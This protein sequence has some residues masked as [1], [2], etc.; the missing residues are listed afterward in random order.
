MVR[1][2]ERTVAVWTRPLGPGR[3]DGYFRTLGS[4]SGVPMDCHTLGHLRARLRVG[5][6]FA[7]LASQFGRTPC[8]ISP[9]S[10]AVMHLIVRPLTA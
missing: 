4:E 10:F 2:S 3:A 8:V 6:F 7:Q 1:L 9:V 5:S